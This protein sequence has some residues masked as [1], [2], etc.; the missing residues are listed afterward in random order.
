MQIVDEFLPDLKFTDL[1]KARLGKKS[2]QITKLPKFYS[3]IV[4]E[5][6][7]LKDKEDVNSLGFEQIRSEFIWHNKWITIEKKPFLWKSWLE[8]NIKHVS[9]LLN[10]DGTFQ[11]FVQLGQKYDI[12]VSF[13]DMLKIKQALPFIWR[14]KLERSTSIITEPVVY[15]YNPQTYFL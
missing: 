6:N 11:T 5:W 12:S 13:L 10:E 1:I 8:R 15:L 14:K 2:A 7:I 3:D 4:L 9:D